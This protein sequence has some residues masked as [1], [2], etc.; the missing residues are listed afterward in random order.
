MDKIHANVFLIHEKIK[1]YWC[2][3]YR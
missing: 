1:E 3:S 2:S